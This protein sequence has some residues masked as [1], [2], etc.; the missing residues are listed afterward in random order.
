VDS[1]VFNDS[2]LFPAGEREA[3]SGILFAAAAVATTDDDGWGLGLAKDAHNGVGEAL[4]IIINCVPNQMLQKYIS[5]LFLPSSF[6]SKY[7]Q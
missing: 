7:L 6:H 4:L 1:L 2:F 3:I 5:F